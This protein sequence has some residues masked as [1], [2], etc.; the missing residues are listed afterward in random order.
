[1]IVLKITPGNKSSTARP[2]QAR[3]NGAQKPRQRAKAIFTQEGWIERGRAQNAL[4]LAFGLSL[5]L[6]GFPHD[7]ISSCA[8]SAWRVLGSKEIFF[9]QRFPPWWTS[10][11]FFGLKNYGCP[12]NV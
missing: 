7:S 9:L 1:V 6:G 2:A 4:N 3:Q 12:D 10:P 8:L 11:S 5:L